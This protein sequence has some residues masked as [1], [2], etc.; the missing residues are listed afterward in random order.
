MIEMHAPR[1]HFLIKANSQAYVHTH[2]V[3]YM[4]AKNC[5]SPPPIKRN[6]RP[7]SKIFAL[8]STAI[9]GFV[10]HSPQAGNCQICIHFFLGIVPYGRQ[11][12]DEARENLHCLSMLPVTGYTCIK[13]YNTESCVSVCVSLL[14]KIA[15]KRNVVTV[16]MT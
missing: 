5:S 7:A 13:Q 11:Y 12:D 2:D 15:Q 3:L 14:K 1:L 16:N 8:Y 6:S 10:L 9:F 4:T